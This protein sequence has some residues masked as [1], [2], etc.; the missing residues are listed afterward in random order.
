MTAGGTDLLWL[1]HVHWGVFIATYLF[2]GG[3]SGGAC[4]T[5]TWASFMRSHM[6]DDSTV[7][8]L[9]LSRTDSPAHRFACNETARWG[10]LLAVGA[11]AI[12]GTALLSHLGAPLRALSFPVL[13]SNFGSW[14]VIGTWFIVLFAIFAA[15]EAVWLLFGSRYAGQSGLS[16]FPRRILRVVDSLMP[17][18]E[19]GGLLALLDS[20]ADSTR[21]SA[22]LRGVFRVLGSVFAVGVVVYTAMLL[23][24][25]AS[26]PFWTRQ[27]LPFVFLMSGV[28]TGISAALLGT[29]LS[30]GALTR[31]NHRFCLTDDVIIVVELFFIWGLLTLLAG[32]ASPAAQSTYA[33]LFGEYRLQFL[34]GVLVVGTSVPVAL[35]LTITG[36]HQFT[37]LDE[38]TIGRWVM[39]GGYAT[40]YV[41]V[42]AGGFLL[43]WVVLFAA[44]KNPLAVPGL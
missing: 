40:K 42:L 16:F 27:Y 13:F 44:V 31:T 36:L 33:A 8:R 30:G 5:S 4:L 17:W 19:D 1:P 21:P 37:D 25:L 20:I 10:A 12:G 32:S 11:I 7:G 28:S 15:L 26:V 2:L 6:D 9:L 14:L 29:V 35:S 24:D 38:S 34:V 22:R 18:A 23:S 41:L 43:R 39:T 3:V